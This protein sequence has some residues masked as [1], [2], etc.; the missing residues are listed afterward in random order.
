MLERIQGR[1]FKQTGE[2]GMLR[3]VIAAIGLLA[4]GGSGCIGGRIVRHSIGNEKKE[5]P[6]GSPI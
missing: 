2:A 6:V 3:I 5:S 4:L 1:Q